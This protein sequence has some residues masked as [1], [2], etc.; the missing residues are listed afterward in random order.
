MAKTILVIDDESD[1]LWAQKM[2]LEGAGY[3]VLCAPTG[4]E[5][6]RILKQAPVDLVVTD[7]MMPHGDGI[8]VA[9]QIKDMVSPI[10]VIVMTGGGERMTSKD[11]LSFSKAFFSASLTKPF[12]AQDLLEAIEGLIAKKS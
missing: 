9:M 4:D 1:I 11:A 10:P 2:V 5:G 6:C 3:Y 12:S 7:L 8:Q